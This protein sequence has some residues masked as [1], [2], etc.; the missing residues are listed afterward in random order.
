LFAVAA[1]L[2]IAVLVSMRLLS[3]GGDGG[4]D[5]G[6]GEQEQQDRPVAAVGPTE[7]EREQ[8][9]APPETDQES[10]GTATEATPSASPSPSEEDTGNGV[11][12]ATNAEIPDDWVEYAPGDLPYRVFHPPGW[13][14]SRLDDT[15]TDIRDPDSGTYLR[16]D[17]VAARRDPLGAWEE[18]EPAFAASHANYERLGLDETT[19]QGNRAALWEYRYEDGGVALHAYNLGVN[20]DENGFAL[21]LQSHA[22]DWERAQELWPLFLSSYRFEP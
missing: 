11:L 13:T 15:R 10:A 3:G 22:D 7:S 20:A 12:P 8:Q 19:Y 1:V 5:G 2:L 6:N 9:A 14:V 17:W 16:L 18:N 21:N 4:G